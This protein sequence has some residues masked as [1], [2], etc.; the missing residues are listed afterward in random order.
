MNGTIVVF[1][2]VTAI[3]K[4]LKLPITNEVPLAIIAPPTPGHPIP[5]GRMGLVRNSDFTTTL[6]DVT[7]THPFPS[8]NQTITIGRPIG[9]GG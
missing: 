5:T 6:A 9:K 2:C 7:I 4:S 3:F 8:S 1:Q